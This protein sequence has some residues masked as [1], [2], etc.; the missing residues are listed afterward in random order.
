MSSS[1][2]NKALACKLSTELIINDFEA[3]IFPNTPSIKEE[4]TLIMFACDHV[5]KEFT[6]HFK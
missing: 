5:G 4:L 6:S 1:N 2:F 3:I